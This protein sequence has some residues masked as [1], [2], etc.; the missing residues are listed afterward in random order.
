[1]DLQLQIK[2]RAEIVIDSSLMLARRGATV[3]D[4]GLEGIIL[5]DYVFF[6]WGGGRGVK[7]DDQN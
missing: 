2:P 4:I 7:F 5:G 1:M 3:L 6:F